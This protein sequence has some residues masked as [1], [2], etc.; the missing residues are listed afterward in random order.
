MA[1]SITPIT[2]EGVFDS[3]TYTQAIKV[4][5]AESIVFVSGQV[6]YDERGGVAH[7]G[8]F[9]AQARATFAALGAQVEAA[10]AGVDDI[11]KLTIYLV[12]LR[13]RDQLRAIRDEFFGGRAPTATL[14]GVTGLALPGLLLEV[15]AIAVI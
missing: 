1:T 7:P 4:T 13:D 3:P 15:E 5:G 11:V 9:A 2:A 6:A 8:D 14:V 10:G 12:D